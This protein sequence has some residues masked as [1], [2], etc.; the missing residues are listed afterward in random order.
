[1]GRGR[2]IAAGEGDVDYRREQAAV[3]VQ[4]GQTQQEQEWDNLSVGPNQPIRTTKVKKS[5]SLKNGLFKNYIVAP[6]EK[7][8]YLKL[9]SFQRRV[10]L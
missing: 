5:V 10:H 7:S 9:L 6:L 8:A 2:G 1:M 3:N 4:C